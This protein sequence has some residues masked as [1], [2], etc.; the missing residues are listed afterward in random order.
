MKREHLHPGLQTP[1]LGI[2]GVSRAGLKYQLLVDNNESISHMANC[3][4]I[5]SVII[6]S[7]INIYST[8]GSCYYLF[9]HPKH[10]FWV[11]TL[12]LVLFLALGKQQWNKKA[13]IDPY[14]HGGY[15]LVEGGAGR[16][17]KINGIS[18]MRTNEKKAGQVGKGH[19]KRRWGWDIWWGSQGKPWEGDIWPEVS[20]RE[21]NSRQ[22]KQ[23]RP[24]ALRREQCSRKPK[25]QSSWQNEI[26]GWGGRGGGNRERRR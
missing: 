16:D 17:E 15:I 8:L 1:L 22:R 6:F 25:S 19:R 7:P 3:W 20:K 21:D 10:S 9:L 26:G 4:Y 2:I 12:Y 5:F 14:P 24:E 18:V 13:D 11:P 23:L